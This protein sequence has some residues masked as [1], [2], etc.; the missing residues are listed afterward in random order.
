MKNLTPTF[1]YNSVL[2]LSPGW[3]HRQGVKGLILDMDNTIALHNENTV[4][5]GLEDWLGALRAAGIAVTVLS[6]NDEERVKPLADRLQ[7]GY[8]HSAGKPRRR[9]YFAAMGRMGT[10]PENTLMAGDQLFTDIWG[11]SRAGLRTVL[12]T[13]IAERETALIKLKRIL[14]RPFLKKGKGED[15]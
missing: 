11:A 4:L 9:G 7:I 8:V 12:V 3:L 15:T 1:Q 14:E 5:P 6:N 13:P 2:E 10:G